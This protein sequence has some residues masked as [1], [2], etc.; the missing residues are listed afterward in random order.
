M[1][2]DSGRK[3]WP[4]VL[5]VLAFV[6]VVIAAI[7]YVDNN[8][9][10]RNRLR[11]TISKETTY[12]T[13]PL[14]ADG[15]P[16][17]IAA[18]NQRL[19]EGVTP[20]NNSAVLFLKAVGPKVIDNNEFRDKYYQMLDIPPLP[21]T[22]DYF[23]PSDEYQTAHIARQMG[24]AQTPE[25][26]S[27]EELRERLNKQFDL[28]LNQPWSKEEYPVWAEWVAANEK[29]LTLIVEATGRPRR[30]DPLI[31]IDDQ[32]VFCLLLPMVMRHRDV[33]RALCARAM[34]QIHEGKDEEAWEDLLACHRL[35]RLVGQGAFLVE[36][37]VAISIDSMACAGDRALLEHGKL[38]AGQIAKMRDDLADLPAMP[39][40]AEKLDKYERLGLLDAITAFAQGRVDDLEMP[41]FIGRH[42]IAWD[43][44]LRLANLLFDQAADACRL[45]TRKERQIACDEIEK[46]IKQL[47]K[48]YRSISKLLL[49][50]RRSAAR[51]FVAM[52]LPAFSTAR[53]VEDRS[54]MQFELTDLAFALAAYRAEHG[55]YPAKLDELV[56]EYVKVIPKDIFNND[57]D[58][59]Y[60]WQDNGY[61]LYSVGHNG[62][63]DG[64]KGR[65]DRKEGEDWDDLIVRIPSKPEG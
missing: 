55:A 44:S 13:E 33:A 3:R 54:T 1:A 31:S 57:A 20:E 40:I 10:A 38:S 32:S 29:P 65:D 50:P 14:R 21:E 35:A 26:P 23:I 11:V 27:E 34:F 15:Y 46:K 63:D 52:Y 28:A 43:H 22:G 42:I 12:I 48:E 8:Q 62:K 59:H 16:D 53:N 41:G 61:L 36:A 25:D 18:L 56:P 49:S 19:S 30:Y 6:V 2:T 7:F 9:A 58:L 51:W 17:Y 24:Q 5:L 47:A 39:S 64:G 45:P 4:K 37:L 60:T